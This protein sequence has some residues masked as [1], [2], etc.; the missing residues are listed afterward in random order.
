MELGVANA[1]DVVGVGTNEVRHVEGFGRSRV[2]YWDVV[3][4]C[5]GEKKSSLRRREL[6]GFI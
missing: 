1:D 6:T 5:V 3:A 2:W 4:G